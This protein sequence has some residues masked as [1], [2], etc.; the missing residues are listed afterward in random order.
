MTDKSIRILKSTPEVLESIRNVPCLSYKDR[1]GTFLRIK[2]EIILELVDWK[3]VKKELS[4]PTTQDGP[5]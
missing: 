2:H 3:Q 5:I 4:I 1:F